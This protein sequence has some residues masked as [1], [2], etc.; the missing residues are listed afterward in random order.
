MS[1]GMIEILVRGAMV[2]RGNLLLCHKKGKSYCFL[3]GGHI[4]FGES[5]KEALRREIEE[6]IGAPC[7][8]GRFLGAC[9]HAFR[10]RR[11][12]VCEVN[13]VFEMRIRGLHPARSVPSR[14]RKLEFF[15]RPLAKLRTSNLEPSSLR[16]D[17]PLWLEKTASVKRW[18][19]TF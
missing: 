4:E 6:E 3:P 9:E 15:W 12:R 17:L 13:F 10:G 18:S 14:E 1:L 16:R 8:V 2:R 7:S 11:Q 5:A 19:S